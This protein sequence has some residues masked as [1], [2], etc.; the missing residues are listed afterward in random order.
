MDSRIEVIRGD[1][2]QQHV[3][4]IVNAAN[5]FLR[6]GGGVDG[7]IHRAAGPGLLEESRILGGCPV[8]EARATGAYELPARWVIHAVG[9]VWRGGSQ[10][11]HA[12]LASAYRE[13]LVIADA[14]GARTVAFPLI[15][16]GAYGF[17]L[18]DACRIALTEIEDFLQSN[19]VLERVTVVCYDETALSSCQ[20][21]AS[22]LR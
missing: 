20:E 1:I 22:A 17:P 14:L 19:R 7:A 21:A 2:A 5:P 16:T 3:D 8:G 4:A 15:S 10:N 11:E 12:L 9:P 6:G 18:S 13:S